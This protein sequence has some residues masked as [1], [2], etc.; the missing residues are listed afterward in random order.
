MQTEG[1]G[2]RREGEG[3]GVLKLFPVAGRNL[4]GTMEETLRGQQKDSFYSAQSVSL[5]VTRS[6][7]AHPQTHQFPCGNLFKE[8]N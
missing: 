4:M 7:S 6:K 5:T 8:D 1:R 2:S 3:E